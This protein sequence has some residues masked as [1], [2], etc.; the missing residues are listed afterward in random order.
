MI[1]RFE[2]SIEVAPIDPDKVESLK[3][4]GHSVYR[5]PTSWRVDAI[6][7]VVAQ[8]S[9]RAQA[10]VLMRSIVEQ[11]ELETLTDPPSFALRDPDDYDTPAAQLMLEDVRR[12]YDPDPLTRARRRWYQRWMEL[13]LGERKGD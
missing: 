9:V 12:A 11:F 7:P 4:A 5:G 2:V 6:A 10:H 1:S 8:G 3:A 13:G